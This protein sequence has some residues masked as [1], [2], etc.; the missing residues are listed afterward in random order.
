MTAE[1]P[2]IDRLFVCI[3]AQK[4]G[5]TWLAR[6][7]AGHPDF[8]LTPVKEIHYFDH[9]RGITAH[10]SDRKRRSRYRKYHQRLWTQWR[11]WA[12]LRAQWD[13]YRDYLSDPIDDAWYADLFRRRG[14][15]RFA[16][17]ATPEY[18]LIGAEGFGHLKRLAP[19]VRILYIMRNPVD[20]AWSQALHYCRSHRLDVAAEPAERL[21]ALLDSEPFEALGD[22]GAVLRDLEAVFAPEQTLLAF[23][24][25]MHADRQAA[26]ERVCRFIGLDF[27][28]STFQGAERRYNPSQ[29]GEMPDEVRDHLRRKYAGLAEDIGRRVGRVP[30][31]W[32]QE[33][34]V[35]DEAKEAS[36]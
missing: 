15:C 26:L 30:E 35:T 32:T 25:D 12:E 14:A 4:A 1:P 21:I 22:Y 5:T 9:V 34:R 6:M 29:E 7:L 19:E 24:E 36:G 23:Y 28:R 13:W 18:A 27:D 10:L 3:G 16:G 8:F 17:E 33:L 2:T 20:R 11:R 31:S